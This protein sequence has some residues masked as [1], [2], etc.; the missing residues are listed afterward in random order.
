MY[1]RYPKPDFSFTVQKRIKIKVQVLNAQNV[2]HIFMGF[3]IF[4][5]EIHLMYLFLKLIGEDVKKDCQDKLF[6]VFCRFIYDKENRHGL[7]L[8]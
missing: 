8:G 5:I 3:N 1:R 4:Y 6:F 7:S 2:N